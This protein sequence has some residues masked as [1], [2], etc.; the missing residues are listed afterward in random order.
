VNEP[1]LEEIINKLKQVLDGKISREEVSDWAMGY[2]N[3]DELKVNNLN[4]W[5]LLKVVG[6]IDLFLAPDEYMYDENDIKSWINEYEK[7]KI[8]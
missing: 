7:K 3:N 4:S 6:S 1:T 5:E 2:L 8:K